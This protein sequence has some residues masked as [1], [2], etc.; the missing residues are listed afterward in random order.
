MLMLLDRRL[1]LL[2]LGR[3][4]L[5]K[6]MRWLVRW[7]LHWWLVLAE[8]LTCLLAGVQIGFLEL[9]D[10]LELGI[11]VAVKMMTGARAVS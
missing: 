9:S 5:L 11:A 10:D 1:L 8:A 3:G 2:N 6:I 7:L 4:L